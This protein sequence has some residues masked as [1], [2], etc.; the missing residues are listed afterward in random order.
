MIS[1]VIVVAAIALTAVPSFGQQTT[2]A[3][4]ENRDIAAQELEEILRDAVKL[5][6]KMDLLTVRARAAMLV[7]FADSVRAEKMFV[8]AWKFAN[9][10]S[11][12]GFDREK[13]KLVVLKYLYAR[14]P[15]LARQLLAQLPAKESSPKTRA[16]GRDNDQQFSSKL[17]SQ[18]VEA[19]PSVAAALLEKSLSIAVTPAGVGTLAQL[20][21]VD[22][23][24]A[25][26]IAA[27]VLD[28]LTV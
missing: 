27:K 19:D 4:A 24:L 11:D 13:A 3:V 10:Q 14:N 23:L 22:Y 17:A 18:L 12:E 15:K 2:K 6:D 16:M 1:R 7:S 5:D 21:Q 25:D 28:G 9:E 26:Y 8:A 20:R